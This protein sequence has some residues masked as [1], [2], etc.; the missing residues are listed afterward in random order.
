MDGLLK[1]LKI[2]GGHEYLPS[3][4]RT[5]L[6]SPRTTNIKP[7]GTEGSYWHYGVESGLFTFFKKYKSYHLAN[8]SIDLMFNIDG[9]PL[10]NSSYNEIWPIL[11]S[12]FKVNYVF[13]I[14]I[15]HSQV[16]KPSNIDDY[17]EDFIQEVN[18][19]IE[20]GLTYEEKCLQIRVHGFSADAPAKSAMLCIKGHCGYNSCTKCNVSG[21]YKERRTCFPDV[22]GEKRT[23]QSFKEH[24]DHQYHLRDENGMLIASPLEKLIGFG[25]VTNVPLNYQHLLCLGIVKKLINAWWTGNLHHRIQFKFRKLVSLKLLS[26]RDNTPHE[27]QRKPR[28]LKYYLQFKATEFRQILLYTGVFALK[29]S[30]SIEKYNNFLTLHIA[31]TIL[32][33]PFLLSTH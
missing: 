31:T 7:I 5:L 11:G 32:C 20:N 25:M 12:I 4:S 19:L 26:I 23:D 18:I 33:S 10:S 9:L 30:L 28:S 6:K 22:I 8:E 1:I 16:R 2:H 15:Y 13:V 17:L 24:T 27:F 21:Y 3:S 14:G 29:Q